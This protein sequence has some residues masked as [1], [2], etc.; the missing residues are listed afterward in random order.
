MSMGKL[1]SDINDRRSQ[2]FRSDVVKMLLM[3][4]GSEAVWYAAINFIV[5]LREHAD[6]SPTVI[7][8]LVDEV[9]LLDTHS[10]KER[11][12]ILKIMADALKPE[13]E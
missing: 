1:A 7:H 3:E 9:Y 6:V 4:F 8:A 10:N 5:I 2:R 12:T 11:Q 13:Q